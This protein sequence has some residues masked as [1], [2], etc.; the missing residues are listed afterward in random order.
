MNTEPNGSRD[1]DSFIADEIKSRIAVARG[2]TVTSAADALNI[3]RDGLSARVNGRAPFSSQLIA[4]VAGLL[5]TSASEIVAAAERR[6]LDAGEGRTIPGVA[7]VG[8]A[9]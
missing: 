2:V 8:D 4:D 3:R 1:L 9:A 7:N 5:G 6:R